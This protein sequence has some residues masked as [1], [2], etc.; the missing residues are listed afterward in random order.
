MS[1]CGLQTQQDTGI[2]ATPATARSRVHHQRETGLGLAEQQGRQLSAKMSAFE[3]DCGHSKGSFS[4]EAH[5]QDIQGV[6]GR[7]SASAQC[8]GFPEER[9]GIGVAPHLGV[10]TRMEAEDD[11]ESIVV[12]DCEDSMLQSAISRLYTPPPGSTAV[13]LHNHHFTRQRLSQRR[14]RRADAWSFSAHSGVKIKGFTLRCRV[15]AGYDWPHALLSTQPSSSKV[16]LAHA[17]SCLLVCLPARRC[18]RAHGSCA[19][20]SCSRKPWFTTPGPQRCRE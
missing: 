8:R 7:G 9:R 12:G 1:P 6:G 13:S 4:H 16:F 20:H 19:A 3:A 10:G 17:Y 14:R 11:W 15:F 2:S 18:C 5:L